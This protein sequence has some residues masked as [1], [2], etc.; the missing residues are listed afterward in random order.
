[1]FSTLRVFSIPSFERL[2]VLTVIESMVYLGRR[3]LARVGGVGEASREPFDDPL[4]R[5]SLVA[6]TPM[7]S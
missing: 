2:V 1:M 6:Q 4:E 7:R 3:P 5:I